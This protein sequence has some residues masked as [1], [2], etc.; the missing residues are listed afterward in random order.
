[1][2]NDVGIDESHLHECLDAVLQ[3]IPVDLLSIS[4]FGDLVQESSPQLVRHLIEALLLEEL[5]RTHSQGLHVGILQ[6]VPVLYLM[7]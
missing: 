2:L 4:V 5:E 6:I 7:N 1:M 3:E